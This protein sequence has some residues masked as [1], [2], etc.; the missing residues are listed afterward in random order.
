M[1][2]GVQPG[3]STTARRSIF[4]ANEDAWQPRT[5]ARMEGPGG[6]KRDQQIDSHRRTIGRFD[7]HIEEPKRPANRRVRRGILRSKKEFLV[8]L[9][10]FDT[11][12]LEDRNAG[13]RVLP[14]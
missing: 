7:G 14:K 1:V 3:A 10:E 8:Q 5:T 13:V 11:G 2:S 6:A 4:S 9:G 12:R